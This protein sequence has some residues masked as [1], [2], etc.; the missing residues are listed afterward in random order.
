[1]L[2]VSAFSVPSQIVSVTFFQL[3]VG[4]QLSFW[5]ATEIFLV[6]GR[7]A[8]KINLTANRVVSEYFFQNATDIFFRCN[9]DFFQP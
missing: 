5:V 9:L 1:M 8:P 4:L 6:V 7:L 2:H 3:Q